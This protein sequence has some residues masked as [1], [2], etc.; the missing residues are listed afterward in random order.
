MHARST[1]WFTPA[2]LAAVLA[3]ASLASPTPAAA[4][5][6]AKDKDRRGSLG[7]VTGLR[8]TTQG[9]REHARYHGFIQ[10]KPP[11]ADPEV[12]YWGGSSCPGQKLN[13]SHVAILVTAVR[14]HDRLELRPY[15]TMGETADRCLVAFDLVAG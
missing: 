7:R 15:Y 11:L 12:Y 3:I 14:D 9:S 2:L 1:S 5:D 13:D 4:T 8:L 6:D 10:I